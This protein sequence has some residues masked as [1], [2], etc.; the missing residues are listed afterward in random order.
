VG[1][2]TVDVI[3]SKMSIIERFW[4]RDA[5]DHALFV[6]KGLTEDQL[7]AAENALRYHQQFQTL[8]RLVQAA[9]S[10]QMFIIGTKK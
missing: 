9:N 7:P 5:A 1:A 6:R 8:D 2:D 3:L 10:D 4:M